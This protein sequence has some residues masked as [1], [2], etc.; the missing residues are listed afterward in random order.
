MWNVYLKNVNFLIYSLNTHSI[1]YIHSQIIYDN[2]NS[3]HSSSWHKKAELVLTNLGK[4]FSSFIK[5]YCFLLGIESYIQDTNFLIKRFGRVIFPI[6]LIFQLIHAKKKISHVQ[7]NSKHQS[8]MSWILNRKPLCQIL[9]AP[10]P[11]LSD[12]QLGWLT[13]WFVK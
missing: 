12:S 7:P 4:H 2:E 5:R 8:M 6:K 9:E 10:V 1:A 13:T 11:T 3:F